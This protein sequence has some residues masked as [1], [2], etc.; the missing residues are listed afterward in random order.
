MNEQKP[1]AWLSDNNLNVTK[2]A[3][4]AESWNQHG[5]K[6]IPLY[7]RPTRRLTDNEICKILLDLEYK[8]D[9]FETNISFGMEIAKAIED[10]LMEI[11]K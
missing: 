8:E 6:P 1:V 4:I 7:T 9:L 10:K 11:N 5:G 3:D 2:H